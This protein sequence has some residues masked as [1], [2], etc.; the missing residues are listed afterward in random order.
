[1][2][3]MTAAQA[4]KLNRMNPTTQEMS[5]GTTLYEASETQVCAYSVL[6]SADFSTAS[7]IFVAPYA[8]RI[9]DV[10]VEAHATEGS[11]TAKI[12][13][14][15]DEIC[16]AIACAADGAV[17]HMS[18]GATVATVARRLLAAGDTVNVQAAGGT[19]ANIKG[20]IT[21]IALRV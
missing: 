12:L 15:T 18:A 21:V 6:K 19:A 10:I 13:K 14:G 7:A 16:T 17:T 4:D 2:A 11:G 9:V 20:R 5:L 8:M 1:M 3:M